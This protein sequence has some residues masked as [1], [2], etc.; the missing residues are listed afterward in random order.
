[1]IIDHHLILLRKPK[2]S[3]SSSDFPWIFCHPA[4]L[5][6]PQSTMKSAMKK[7][8]RNHRAPGEGWMWCSP[9]AR[10]GTQGTASGT[11]SKASQSNMAHTEIEGEIRIG[12]ST[13]WCVSR[14]EWMGM[15]VAG[16]IIH[17][18]HSDHSRKFPI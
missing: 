7:P 8:W 13:Y 6:Y 11:A 12:C 16:I 1:M 5:G 17:K 9:G 15:R 3:I 2:K 4:S 10:Q 14:R 18:Y